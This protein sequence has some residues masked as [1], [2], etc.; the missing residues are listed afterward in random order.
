MVTFL[1][2][3]VFCNNRKYSA[4]IIIIQCLRDKLFSFESLFCKCPNWMFGKMS[5]NPLFDLQN[6]VP[7]SLEILLALFISSTACNFTFIVILSE[8][9]FVSQT[10]RNH[11]CVLCCGNRHCWSGIACF[12]LRKRALVFRY[13]AVIFTEQIFTPTPRPINQ[14]L[15]IYNVSSLQAILQQNVR[16][17][18]ASF[19]LT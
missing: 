11:K 18:S 14:H 10:K 3:G 16:T 17:L 12:G 8:G 15:F 19:V 9:I 2:H 13:Q 5:P 1:V 4:L 6:S 7:Q